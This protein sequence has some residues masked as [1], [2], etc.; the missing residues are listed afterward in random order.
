MNRPIH[1]EIP[2]DNP[3]RAIGFYSKIFGWQFS[4]WEGPQP[5][6]MIKTGSDSPG[7][8]GGM[9]N[10]MAPGQ[11]IANTVD[12]A[13]LDASVGAV[14]SAGGTIAMPRMAVPG[15][16]WL[17]YGVDTE[18]NTFGMMQNDSAAA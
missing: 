16:G 8:D 18:G 14:V 12:V 11:G 7:I 3:D 2:A 5:Y 17:A 1:F 13:D 6:W 4:K 10:R 15:I 9:M